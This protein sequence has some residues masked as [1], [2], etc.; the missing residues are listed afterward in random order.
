MQRGTDGQEGSKEE[1]EKKRGE[2]AVGGLVL[3]GTEA[4]SW[5]EG[6]EKVGGGYWQE[7]RGLFLSLSGIRFAWCEG[8]R[9]GK[10]RQEKRAQSS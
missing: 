7:V 9:R 3:A 2:S 5:G 4:I 10:D 6:E 8:R 1:E